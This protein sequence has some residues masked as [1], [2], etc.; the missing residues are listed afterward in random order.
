MKSKH[1]TL[2]LLVFSLFLA[3]LHPHQT[4]AQAYVDQAGTASKGGAYVPQASPEIR[5]P[6]KK[7]NTRAG[8]AA[9]S[10]QE[11]ARTRLESKLSQLP[12]VGAGSSALVKLD[13]DDVAWPTVGKGLAK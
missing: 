10:Q 9:A 8:R 4:M 3:T 12:T 1:P 13:V 5:R 2:A 6:V 11:L 7:T